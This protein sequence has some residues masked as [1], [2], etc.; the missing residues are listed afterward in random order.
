MNIYDAADMMT[1]LFEAY[2]LFLLFETFLSRRTSV[3]TYVYYAGAILLAVLIDVCNLLFL[4]SAVNILAMGAAA[5]AVSFVYK[6]NVRTRV[7][8]CAFELMVT[9]IT[10][11]LAVFVLAA[12]LDKTAAQMTEDGYLRLIGT[13][14]SKLLGYAVIKYTTRRA[15]RNLGY[16]DTSYWI[17]FC[18]IFLSAALTMGTFFTVL[19]EGVSDY[20][21]TLIIACTCGVCFTTVFTLYLYEHAQ[22]QRDIISKQR[23]EQM[24]MEEQIKY[25]N[26][27]IGSQKK[28]KAL[29][30][31]LKNHLITLKA[32]VYG[33]DDSRTLKYVDSLLND[34]LSADIR[35]NTGNIA[36]D[37]ILNVK[38]E[39]A[40]KNGITFEADLKIPSEL[41]I[42]D[43]D[44]SVIF[45]NALDNAIEACEKVLSDKIIKLEIIYG[46]NTLLCKIENSCP[47][48]IDTELKT[49]KGN[50][51]D[52]GMGRA[53]IARALERYGGVSCA[54]HLGSRYILSI[55]FTNI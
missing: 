19:R 53:N 54:E 46:E 40:E 7:L 38:A 49:T 5:F 26:S 13:A 43:A 23:M 17:L 34:A 52:H 41:P 37:A 39:E 32:C 4:M 31:D 10:E 16:L 3:P 28:I 6:G 1:G 24:K 14:V 36:L 45:G 15:R 2:Y 20:A 18:V 44:I 9:V 50:N 48:N 33:G 29:R 25:Y 8:S 47:E 11:V 22:K 27:V 21:Q 55:A 30:H 35:F 51:E 42:A 12:I